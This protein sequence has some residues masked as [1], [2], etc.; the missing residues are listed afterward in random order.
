MHISEKKEVLVESSLVPAR[1]L[2]RGVCGNEAV[3]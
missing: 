2:C 1:T 3:K